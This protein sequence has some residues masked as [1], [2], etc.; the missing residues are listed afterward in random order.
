MKNVSLIVLTA[1]VA[2][3]F[4]GCGAPAANTHSIAGTN[5]N[6]NTTTAPVGPPT[7]EGLKALGTRAF[8]AFK[9]KDGKFFESFLTDDFVGSENGKRVDKAATVA[10]IAGLKCQIKSFSFSDEKLTKVGAATA[11][12]TMKGAVDGTCEGRP[13]PSP[14]IS[15]SLYVSNGTDWQ[16]AW[17]GEVPVVDPKVPP[18][19]SRADTRQTSYGIGAAKLAG[20]T[21]AVVQTTALASIEKAVWEAWMKRDGKRLDELTARELAF[22]NIFGGYFTN[23]AETLKNWTEN[24]CEIKSVDVADPWSVQVASDTAVFI[25]KGTANGTCFGQK[26]GPVLGTSIYVKDGDVWKVAFTMNMPAS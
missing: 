14:F 23:R 16:G 2:A 10:M 22:V 15:A 1:I 17:H 26:V 18:A 12:I 24:P 7:L 19:P 11:V 8:E 13:M 25:H 4:V 20:P 3:A 6:T 5:A 9:N 21:T